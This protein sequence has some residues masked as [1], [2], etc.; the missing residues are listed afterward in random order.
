MIKIPSVGKFNQPNNSDLF[1]NIWYSKNLNFDEEGY[2]KLSDRAV[3]L[4]SSKVDTEFN[5]PTALGR[6]SGGDFFIA[7]VEHPYIL[8][9]ADSG[10]SIAQDT[11]SDG[12]AAPD[13]SFSTTGIWFNNK[14]NITTSTKLYTKAISTGNW[15]DQSVSLTTGVSHP[16]CA[17]EKAGTILVGNANEV[18]QFD[19]SYAA[20]TLAQL[21]IS[22]GYEVIGIAYNN[23]QAGI[24]TR[25]ASTVEGQNKE[26]GFFLWDGSESSA[27]SMYAVGSDACVAIA[28]YKSSF[29][30]ITRTGELLYFNGGG[31]DKLASFPTYFNDVIWG[32]LLNRD[33]YGDSIKVDGDVIYINISNDITDENKKTFSETMLGGIWCY[34]PV[35]G[36]YHKIS[37]SNSQAVMMSVAAEDINTTTGTFTTSF[38]IGSTVP[39]TGTPVKILNTTNGGG[40]TE[41]KM[42]WIIKVSSNAFKLA[43]TKAN[44]IALIPLTIT[45]ASN[46][47][48]MGLA[49]KD[50]GATKVERMGAVALMGTKQYAY[51]DFI[52]GGEVYDTNSTSNYGHLNITVAD[53]KNIGYFITP[54]IA[55]QN[56][57]DN[58]QKLFIKYRPLDTDDKIIIK[59]KDKEYI[60]LPEQGSCTVVSSTSFT[61]TD[62]LYQSYIATTDLECEIVSGSGAGQMSKVASITYL[63]GTYTVTVEDEIDGWVAAD[64]C[65]V[66]IDNWKTMD[67]ITSADSQ[68]WKEIPITTNSKWLKVKV[69]LEGSAIAIEELQ[70][71]TQ[72]HIPSV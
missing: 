12:D 68:N 33:M 44:A 65:Y 7:A 70:I 72:P 36:L 41:G 13:M 5:I 59:Y 49:L 2:L 32:D 26:A 31:F 40:I 60:D 50:Y 11:D 22:A 3:S 1:G 47:T 20:G 4:I 64:R 55:S 48:L 28:P 69:V 62:D 27:N 25:L 57:E 38:L 8:S 43:S 37:P 17:F 56:V 61:T 66:K 52:F 9:I 58:F 71:I 16:L 14:W 51:S 45:A 18:K 15:T 46:T 39:D 24:I 67:T 19:T 29:V 53:F 21:T 35:I 6:Y 30:I 63:T 23:N 10:G 42:Y 34:D 54:K